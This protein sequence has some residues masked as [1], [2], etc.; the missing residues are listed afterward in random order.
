MLLCYTVAW[1]TITSSLE[2]CHGRQI[3]GARLQSLHVFTLTSSHPHCPRQT[4]SIVVHC[5][6]AES[7]Q[8][9]VKMFCVSHTYISYC[10][11]KGSIKRISHQSSSRSRVV[12]T[13]STVLWKLG[14]I[15]QFFN[16]LTVSRCT[17]GRHYV[18]SGG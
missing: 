5:V 14:P 17:P 16:E 9:W 15:N 1:G 6:Q 11:L 8:I 13:F 10:C 3:E 18:S 2:N 7:V 12:C 4:S